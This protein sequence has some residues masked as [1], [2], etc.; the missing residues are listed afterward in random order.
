MRWEGVC[1]CGLM[2][3][4]RETSGRERWIWVGGECVYARTLCVVW[5]TRVILVVVTVLFRSFVLA[6]ATF[7]VRFFADK[8]AA[9][10]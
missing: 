7:F 8:E 5:G 10:G 4:M 2:G 3:L 6:T 9:E 1:A